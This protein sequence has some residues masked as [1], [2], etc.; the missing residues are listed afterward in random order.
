MVSI[1]AMTVGALQND[2]Y[3]SVSRV[4]FLMARWF[5]PREVV[6]ILVL[7]H[8]DINADVCFDTFNSGRIGTALVDGDLLWHPRQVDGRFSVGGNRH[9]RPIRKKVID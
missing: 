2:L 5:F 1:P 4:T 6:E 9:E 7:A 3:P 8:S